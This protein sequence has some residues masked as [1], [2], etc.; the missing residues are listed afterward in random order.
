M[1]TL[2]IS[3]LGYELLGPV[4]ARALLFA[5]VVLLVLW[6]G[7]ASALESPLATAPVTFRVTAPATTP[8]GDPVSIAGD[9]QGWNPGSPTHRLTDLGG[10]TYEITLDLTI[11]TTIQ[12]KFTRGDWSK[13]EKGPSG[14]EI[15]NRTH[16]VSGAQV[17]DLTVAN[18]ADRPANS[19]ITGDVTTHTVPGFL[20]GRRVWVYL[21]PDY[22]AQTDRRYPVLYMFDGQNVFDQATS[23][24]GEWGVDETCESLIASGAMAPIIV[25]A[26][27]NGGGSR[28]LEYTPWYDPNFGSGGGGEAHLQQ[29]I[30][31]LIPWVN[32]NY[33]TLAH[34]Q[35]TGI[36]GSSLGGLMS[37]YAA[38]AHPEVFGRIGALS[39]SI[40]WNDRELLDYVQSH[41]KPDS[42]LYADMGTLESGSMV[43]RDGNGIDD[44]IDNL[45][46]LRDRMT[47]QGFVLGND[48]TIVEDVGGRHN[49]A[50]WRQ[51]FPG[52]L[53]FL[54][55]PASTS[56]R[57]ESV[58]PASSGVVRVSLQPNPF[59]PVTTISFSVPANGP[60]RLQVFDARGRLVR[61]LVE[62][63]LTAGEHR[64]RWDGR[65][66][67]GAEV[68][69]GVYRA[70]VEVEGSVGE[71][72]MVLVR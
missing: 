53:Q 40:W 30:D 60:V 68:A 37:V 38:Y 61:T 16:A 49:E 36:A 24:A 12:F 7:T 72:G 67:D 4:G 20:N 52:A 26:V 19:T 8:P 69:S 15:A 71:R 28:I 70:R 31:V 5:C 51:R 33:R 11:G 21:P 29:F 57:D 17:L 9:F 55:P 46:A 22:D 45:R 47:T 66:E 13:V 44:S 14:E 23:F 42:R 58:P 65:G 1:N 54:F 32:A 34:P 3:T 64:V 50:Y 10:L 18:W 25:V 39:P 62:D 6:P 56:V 35:H 27:D 48:L 63:V 2:S 41:G 59:N 43:D